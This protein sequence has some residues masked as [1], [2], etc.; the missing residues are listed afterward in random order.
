MVMNKA[1]EIKTMLGG[2]P[3]VARAERVIEKTVISLV[4]DVIIMTIDG[5]RERIVISAKMLKIRAE[6]VPVET[7]SIF[8]LTL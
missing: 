5:A 8:K 3:F 1:R 7:S 4:K 2:V 6:A